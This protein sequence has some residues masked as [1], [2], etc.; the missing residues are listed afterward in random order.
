[1]KITAILNTHGVPNETLDT[2]DSIRHYMT[3][4]I[5]VVVD[6]VAWNQYEELAIPAYKLKGFN[7][8]WHRS[9]YRNIVLGLLTAGQK[10]IADTDWFCYLEYD[11]LVTSSAYKSDLK[12]LEKNG[13]WLAGNDYRTNQNVNLRYLET[14]AKEKFGEKVYMLGACLFYHRDF[15]KVLLENEILERFLYYTNG[16]QQGFFPYFEAWDLTEHAL[17]TMVKHFGGGIHQFAVYNKE[18]C[19]W[20]GNHTRYPIRFRP[21]LTLSE[22]YFLHASIMH[23]IKSFDNPLRLFHRSKRQRKHEERI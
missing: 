3:D 4:R 8:N 14:I 9:P 22:D 7:H 13:V 16:F 2:I 5:M 6:G 10:W 1:M 23:P 12:E 17:P 21:E 15:I 20:A 11:V 18:L 19:I